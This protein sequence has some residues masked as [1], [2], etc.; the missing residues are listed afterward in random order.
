MYES[1]EFFSN[2]Q[3]YLSYF[4]IG[5]VHLLAI[6]QF[7]SKLFYSNKLINVKDGLSSRDFVRKFSFMEIMVYV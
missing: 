4:N 2:A 3:E 7:H 1:E 5:V 6:A